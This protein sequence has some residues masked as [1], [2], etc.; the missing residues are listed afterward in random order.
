MAQLIEFVGTGGVMEGNFNDVPI[1]VNQDATLDF[2]TTQD[3]IDCGSGATIDNIFSGGGS[4]SLW[5]NIRSK[6][7]ES[8]DGGMLVKKGP[9]EVFSRDDVSSTSCT[10][11]FG[12]NFSSNDGDWRL[13][14]SSIVYGNWYHLAI[15]YDNGATANNP[16]IYLNGVAYTVGGTPALTEST[17][18]TGSF[19]TDAGDNLFIGNMSATGTKTTDGKIADVR[20]YDDVLTAAEV[21]VLASRINIDSALGPGTA[22]LEAWWKIDEG[23]GTSIADSSA[24]SNTGTLSGPDWKFDAFSV[25]VQ[26]N[27]TTTDGAVTVTQ[28]KLEGLGLTS[29]DFSGTDQLVSCAS[30]IFYDSK[31]AFSVSAWINHD[32]S[33]D[34]HLLHTIVNARDGGNDGMALSLDSTNDRIRFRIGDG[35]SDDLYSANSSISNST[36]HHIVATRDASNNTAIYIDGVLATTGTSS[37][38]ITILT[39]LGIGGR[40]E[41]TSADEFSG[42]IRNVGCWSYNLSADQVTSLYSGNYS[43]IPNHEYKIDNGTGSTISDTG[44]ETPRDGSITGATWVNG[45]LDLDS[46]L[47]IAANGTLSAPRG[48][49]ELASNFSNSGAYTHNSGLI[50]FTI[51][52][53]S[54]ISG[55]TDTSFYNL[56][57][58]ATSAVLLKIDSDDTTVINRLDLTNSN[59]Y[60]DILDSTG[61]ATLTIGDATTQGTIDGGTAGRFRFRGSGTNQTRVYGAAQLYLSL[62]HI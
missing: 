11:K 33:H 15:T 21:E 55:S 31:T 1:E 39:A 5:F 23:T 30:N 41:S 43:V 20:L 36:W 48:T 58:S 9:W 14:A 42:R 59:S 54:A 18:P 2:N 12:Y 28:G 40:P 37:K 61:N 35:S 45:T 26:D 16:T 3:D 62:I 13:P 56:N 6:S 17:A 49:L 44:T 47:T 53:N 60:F 52:A 34:G 7:V 38:T 29:L 46:T 57:V 10:I 32:N 4:V 8:D 51:G 22:D 27:S 24:N 25:A 19:D 50:D